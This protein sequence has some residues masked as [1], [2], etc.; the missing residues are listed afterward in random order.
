MLI[1]HGTSE[2]IQKLTTKVLQIAIINDD[3]NK[4]DFSWLSFVQFNCVCAQLLYG[5]LGQVLF[6]IVLIPD[7]CHLIHFK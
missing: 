5:T 7:L 1:Y 3:H 6:L 2:Y 4:Y